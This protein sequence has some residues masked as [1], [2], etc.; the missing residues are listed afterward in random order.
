MKI[1]KNRKINLIDLS[2]ILKKNIN[3]KKLDDEICNFIKM[4]DITNKINNYIPK[5]YKDVKNG[6]SKFNHNDILIAKIT[7]CF[8]NGKGALVHLPDGGFGST[9]FMVISP[10]NEFVKD[11]IYHLTQSKRFRLTGGPLMIGS[12]GQRRIPKEFVLNYQI[13]SFEDVYYFKIGNFLDIK[14][15]RLEKIKKLIEKIEIRNK[16]YAEKLLSGELSVENNA[17]STNGIFLKEFVLDSIVSKK[18]TSGSTPKNITT[19]FSETSQIKYYKVETLNEK[20]IEKYYIT[21]K[22]NNIMSRSILNENDILITIAGTLGRV[23]IVKDQDLPAN[24]NQ[25]IAII[26]VDEKKCYKKYVYHFMKTIKSQIEKNKNGGAIQ[27]LNLTTLSN[28]K[29][30]LPDS[31]S[32]QQ[33]VANFLDKLNDE[34]EKIEKLLKLEEQRFEWLSDKLLSGEYIIED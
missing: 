30:M 10:Y 20:L 16:Y 24:I 26:R 18:I 17:I 19:E 7:P 31:I 32:Y 25:A 4:E 15:K 11:Y 12:G 22:D 23:V 6:F 9:E 1:T 13:P 34:K 29:I 3:N 28:F 14:L 5:E 2:M 21:E 8:E 33:E 27:N